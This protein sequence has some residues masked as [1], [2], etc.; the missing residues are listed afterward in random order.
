MTEHDAF[1][2]RFAAAVRGY[3]GRV[4]SDLDALE[5]AQHVVARAPRRQGFA[6]VLGWRSAAIPRLAWIVLLGLLIA[7]IVAAGIFVGSQPPRP[8]PAVVSTVAPAAAYTA[9]STGGGHTCAIR[10]DGTIECWGANYEGQ[11]TPPEGTFVAVS[12]GTV[13]TCAIRTDG[14][15]ACW[16]RNLDGLATPPEGTFVAVSAGS[17]HTCAIKTDG[18]LQCWGSNDYGEA[19]APSGTYSAVSGGQTRTCAIQTDGTASCWGFEDPDWVNPPS[20]TYV[21]VNTFDQCAIETD[22][23]LTCW[24]SGAVTTLPGAYVALDGGWNAGGPC[25]IRTDGTLACWGLAAEPSPPVGRYTAL[26]SSLPDWQACA[27][28][29]DGALSCW[30]GG[31]WIAE[32]DMG[33]NWMGPPTELIP[34]MRAILPAPDSLRLL[35]GAVEFGAGGSDC[36]VTTP[37]T[38]FSAGDTVHFAAHLE[39]AVRADEVVSIALSVNGAWVDPD[40]LGPGA[41]RTFDGPGDCV[42]G[43]LHWAY[44]APAG[45]DYSTFPRAWTV[46][47]YGV[48][49]S[50]GG[51]VL[52]RGEFGVKP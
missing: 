1:E 17:W 33:G 47:H 8:L 4:S 37:T 9:V 52:S 23:S 41:S 14:K 28:R 15:L 38:T 43:V 29:T 26:S 36:G 50:V 20:G 18:T 12:L 22:G 5:F 35:R 19:T 32:T 11:A 16:G 2:V 34:D 44:V 21:A 6:A 40:P 13:H 39:R 24:S 51:Q 31:D 30:G 3:A 45:V 42:A 48:E 10:T 49:V 25:A 27:I 46:G 7:A